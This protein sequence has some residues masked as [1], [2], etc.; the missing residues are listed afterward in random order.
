MKLVLQRVS[1]AS[2]SIDNLVYSDIQQGVMVLVGITHADTRETADYLVDRLLGLR[3][4]E[5]ENG[6]MNLNVQQV[7]GGV[8]LV[9]Q[10]TLYADTSRGR[11]PGFELAAKPEQAQPLYDYMVE[12]LRIRHPKVATGQF[13]A[14]M[15]I[16]LINDGPVTIILEK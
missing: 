2:L 7:D 1:Q 5:D 3:I 13:G 14:C 4:F 6:K 10:F 16:S 12:Q 15:Q 8:M 11:R 9:S